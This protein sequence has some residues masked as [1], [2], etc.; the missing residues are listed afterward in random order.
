MFKQ[1][2]YI[3]IIDDNKI[4]STQS[5]LQIPRNCNPQFLKSNSHSL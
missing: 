5:D 4:Y 1:Q 2:K 3:H